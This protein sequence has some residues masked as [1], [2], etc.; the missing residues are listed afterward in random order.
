MVLQYFPQER[1]KTFKQHFEILSLVGTLSGER[2]HLHITLGTE[3][4]STI[5]G[6]VVGD[7][8]IYTTAEVVIGECVDLQY[9]READENTGFPELVVKPRWV[10]WI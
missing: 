7:L 2:G 1:V 8:I 3:D 4:G 10:N 5:G 6:H 9:T